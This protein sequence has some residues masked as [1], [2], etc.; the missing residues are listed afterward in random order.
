M[1]L[2]IACFNIESC[3]IAQNAGAHRV[4]FCTDYSKGGY[5]PSFQDIGKTRQLIKIPLHVIIRFKNEEIKPMEDAI[6]FCEKNNID[7][8]V[9]GILRNKTV[10]AQLCHRLLNL[11]GGMKTTFHRYIDECINIE[12]SVQTLMDL[13]FD[14][15]LTSGGEKTA[16]EGVDA[17]SFLRE[18][19]GQQINIIPGGGIR[20]GNIKML[21]EKTKCTT[22]HSAALDLNS[23]NASEKIIKELL[24]AINS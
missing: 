18:K 9:F 7:G 6:K 1:L 11:C 21:R 24:H 16:E 17:I 5:T 10:D 4:E 8:V 14:N 12:E 22:F 2:E 3:V 23:K 19:Y 13:G 20:P 15:V